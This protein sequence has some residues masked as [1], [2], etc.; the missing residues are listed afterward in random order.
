MLLMLQTPLL[1]VTRDQIWAFWMGSLGRVFRVGPLTVEQNV[2]EQLQNLRSENVRLRAE[3]INYQLLRQ[4]LGSYTK[5]DFTV[6]NAEVLAKP[7]DV[8]R[9]KYVVNRGAGDGVVLG[10]PGVINGSTI[11][12]FIVE[13][14]QN[15]SILQLMFHPETSVEA[16]VVRDENSGRGLVKGKSYTG[17]ELATVPRNVVLEKGDEVVTAAQPGFIPHGLFIGEIWQLENE[18]HEPYQ[19]ALLKVPYDFDRMAGIAILVAP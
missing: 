19:R 8:F 12:G 17:V 6:I 2:S 10:A 15:T 16:E 5:D 13:L 1:R 3:N 18:E 14:R 7:I 11:V 9:T 4:Q